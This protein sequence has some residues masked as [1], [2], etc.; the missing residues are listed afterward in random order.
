MATMQP[1]TY[2]Y[3]MTRVIPLAGE[4]GVGVF[5]GT[6]IPYVFGTLAGR[7]G[8]AEEDAQLAEMMMGYWTRFARTGDPNGEDAPVWPRYDPI[9]DSYLKLD[10]NPRAEQGFRTEK[11]DLLEKLIKY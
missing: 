6:E 2:R 10:V 5:H 7:A 9:T 3:V 4:L 11:V 8:F 1:N